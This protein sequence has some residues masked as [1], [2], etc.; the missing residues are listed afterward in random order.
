MHL[1]FTFLTSFLLQA[2]LTGLA[3]SSDASSAGDPP[4]TDRYG[5]PL[6]P[7]V[8]SRLGTERLALFEAR[9]LTFSPDGCL[10]AALKGDT[11][12]RVWDVATGKVLL[13]VK[14]PSFGGFGIGWR[15]LAFSP[16]GKAIA[17][18]C[19]DEKTRRRGIS[20]VRIWEVATGKEVHSLGGLQGSGLNLTFSPDGRSLFAGGHQG[21][22]LRL[23]LAERGGAPTELGRFDS[24]SFLAI[25]RD[26][27]TL[28]AVT[29]EK[30]NRQNRTFIRWDVATGMEIGRHSLAIVGRWYGELSPEGGLFAAPEVDGKSI[31]L[32]DP[33]TGRELA[34]VHEAD[35]PALIHFSADCAV[36]TCTS[37]DGTVRVW[38]T[39]TG[40]MR[41]RFKALSGSIKS[42]ALSS[43]GKRLALAGRT[44]QAVHVWDVAAGRELHSFVGHRGG[45]L[46]IA[47]LKD[48]K[49]IVTSNVDP[50]RIDSFVTEWAE[51]SFR[52]WDVATGAERA[53]TRSD[54]KGEVHYTVLSADGKQ[55]A[56]VIHD[57]TLRLWEVESG[58]ELRSWKV[59]TRDTRSF[60]VLITQPV[61]TPDGKTLLAA[62]GSKIHRWEVATGRELPAFEIEGI[63]PPGKSWCF[64]SPDGQT[65]MVWDIGRGRPDI[66]LVD[67]ANG[68]LRRQLEVPR[69]GLRPP[70]FSPDGRMLAIGTLGEVLLLE[71]ASGQPRG[72]LKGGQWATS[73]AF[74][75]DGRFL[76]VGN[77]TESTVTLWDLS[78]GRVIGSLWSELGM[79][80]SLTFSPDGF[81]LAVAGDF[82]TAL[83]CD[84][85]ELCG[86]KKWEE[87]SKSTTPSAD[88]LEELWT[89][90]SS[91]DG[92]RAYRAIRKLGLAGPGVAP[93]LKARLKSD[94]LP[95]EQR[96]AQL[97]A[98]L[99][100]D[101]FARRERA[102]REL[103]K[104]GAQAEPALRRT[105][106]GKVSAEVRLRV[107]RL[108]KRLDVPQG[109]PPSP[110]LIR[111]RSV[112]ALEANGTQE[113]RQVLAELSENPTD[114]VLRREAKASLARLRSGRLHSR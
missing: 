8:V 7:G 88:E 80:R 90:L 54:P 107:E 93:F 66:R 82:S 86:K 17:L 10:L 45:P 94:K 52:R 21:L 112:E 70:V 74:S 72:R 57:G 13:R 67:A 104:F 40:K 108:L 2:L 78:T 95:D 27:K 16:D 26:G 48:S 101:K 81:R 68:K 15:P 37:K 97:I 59:P 41:T 103:E 4:R 12:L 11:D 20:M 46:A 1:R 35:Y 56:T 30:G 65:L 105:L 87:I 62:E 23:D 91:S 36:M 98:D 31:S 38:D 63:Q 53:V 100:N 60:R 9:C 28:T 49:E 5:D 84:L 73:M 89:E 50:I 44:D 79:V 114:A 42:V 69:A 111:L 22:L 29:K 96:I 64:P 99:D 14:P 58:K 61:F 24:V 43:D 71:V 76:A 47:F 77:N 55:L 92:A 18:A 19:P 85:A 113:A 110:Q 6:P 109:P 39:A 83:V 3:T 25:S 34:K 106:E 75:S 102:S 32:L 51:W 33:L